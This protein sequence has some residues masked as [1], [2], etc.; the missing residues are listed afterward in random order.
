MKPL[1]KFKQWERSLRLK[2]DYDISDPA[3]R[4]RAMRDYHWL[5]HAI[6]RYN[7]HNFFQIAPGV[8]RSNQPVHARFVKYAQMGIKTVINLRGEA[9]HARYLFERE[10]CDALG[11][12]LV[13]VPLKARKAPPVQS[14][15]DL[16]A[17]FRAADKPLMMHCKS[18]A[19][20]AGLAATIY[21]LVIEGQPVAQ[22]R[23]ML[24]PRYIHFKWTK[25]GVLDH[26]LDS[27]AAANAVQPIDFE[28]WVATQYDPVQI[29]AEF[30]AHRKGR[31]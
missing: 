17:V 22:A 25:T 12:K 31:A 2:T 23:R 24:S 11:L 9:T 14:L 1:A 19:D 10:S 30:D 15:L 21:L 29:Q 27:Y 13:S 8:Y 4:A 20:R 18:G 3:Q 16:I 6:L 5:D 26:F 28:T 7:W